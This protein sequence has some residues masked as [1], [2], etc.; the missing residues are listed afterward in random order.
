MMKKYIYLVIYLLSG[1]WLAYS[2]YDTRALLQIG[3]TSHN[4]GWGWLNFMTAGAPLWLLLFLLLLMFLA[5]F[6]WAM[7]FLVFILKNFT[8]F[9]IN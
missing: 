3:G 8:K 6:I 7:L 1:S 2:T 5:D 9:K 4:E